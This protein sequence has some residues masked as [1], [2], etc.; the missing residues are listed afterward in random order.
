MT[1]FLKKNL[2]PQ[3]RRNRSIN[4]KS[5]LLVEERVFSLVIESQN[6]KECSI[7]ECQFTM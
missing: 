1:L 4:D 3:F 7:K 2:F 6:F 5:D